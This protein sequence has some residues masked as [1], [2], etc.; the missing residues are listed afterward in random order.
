MLKKSHILFIIILLLS[1]PVFA[2]SVDFDV[3]FEDII[4]GNPFSKAEQIIFGVINESSDNEKILAFSR[5]YLK[6][7]QSKK[8]VGRLPLALKQVG[9]AFRQISVNDSATKYLFWALSEAKKSK[10]TLTYIESSIYLGLL[11]SRYS[12]WQMVRRYYNKAYEM[13]IAYGRPFEIASASWN[14]AYV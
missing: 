14:M 4:S 2:E 3:E 12:D 10:D 11:Y 13:S 9:N 5:N 1:I 8:S 7:I 6:L